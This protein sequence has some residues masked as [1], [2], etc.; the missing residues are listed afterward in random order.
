MKI[1]HELESIN[2]S[3][4]NSISLKLSDITP[5][6]ESKEY[7]AYRL[8]IDNKSALFRVAKITP[9]KI[10]QFVT[11]WKRNV[12]DNKI[13]PFHFDDDISIVI[14]NVNNGQE[15]GQFIFSRE[16]L[17]KKNMFSTNQKEGKRAIIVYPSW[18]K[19]ISSQA[20][21]TQKWQ[22]D[23]YLDLSGTIDLEQAKKLYSNVF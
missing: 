3:I 21:T 15:S 20:K 23:Y 22:S 17:C 12:N 18:D 7:C 14:V 8:N 9:K 1:P 5:E 16:I 2:N 6:E 11:L 19:P 10:G 4:F 13:Y